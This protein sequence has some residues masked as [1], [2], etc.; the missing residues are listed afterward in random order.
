MSQLIAFVLIVVGYIATWSAWPLW[1]IHAIY[2]MVKT[3]LGFFTIVFSN[4][5]LGLLQFCLG[6][7]IVM[8]GTLIK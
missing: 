6:I 7:T 2:E 8:I 5:G 1:I 4:L 3:E